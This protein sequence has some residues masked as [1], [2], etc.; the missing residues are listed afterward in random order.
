MPIKKFIFIDVIQP[1]RR[2]ASSLDSKRRGCPA[3]KVQQFED[4]A[5]ELQ[6]LRPVQI[7]RPS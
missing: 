4:F 1:H 2:T 7:T 5:A 6:K 3:T